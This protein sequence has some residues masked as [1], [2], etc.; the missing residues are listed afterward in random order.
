MRAAVLE[1]E[2]VSFL[3][4]V[5]TPGVADDPVGSGARDA[6]TNNDDSVVA[7]SSGVASAARAFSGKNTTAVVHEAVIDEHAGRDG[8]PREVVRSVIAVNVSEVSG[9]SLSLVLGAGVG[10]A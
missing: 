3:S 7:V 1:K 5:G 2:D 9:A 8:L 4:P 6:L 10:G